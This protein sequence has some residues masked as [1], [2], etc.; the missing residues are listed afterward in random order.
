MF[1]FVGDAERSSKTARPLEI[2]SFCR[3]VLT[4][5]K[6]SKQRSQQNELAHLSV[7]PHIDKLLPPENL[8]ISLDS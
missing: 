5:K 1:T 6:G 2:L 3:K 4:H 8:S 7:Q